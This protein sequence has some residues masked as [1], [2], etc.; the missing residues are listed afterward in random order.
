MHN[1]NLYENMRSA[2]SEIIIECERMQHIYHHK[3]R[4]AQFLKFGNAT[5]NSTICYS[6]MFIATQC[7]ICA[8]H[9]GKT[10]AVA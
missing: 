6:A 1:I 3:M 8:T 9:G 7:N 10:M 4:A 5:I 2:R